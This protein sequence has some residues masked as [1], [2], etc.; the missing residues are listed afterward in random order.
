MPGPSGPRST[1][2]F[3][4]GRERD[5]VSASAAA[6]ELRR[7]GGQPGALHGAGSGQRVSEPPR[8]LKP[9]AEWRS[10]T[11]APTVRVRRVSR[12]AST[13]GGLAATRWRLPLRA[14]HAERDRGRRLRSR[15]G[16]PHRHRPGLGP[17]EPPCDR[18]R[19]RTSRTG[20]TTRAAVTARAVGVS[21]PPVPPTAARRRRTRRSP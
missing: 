13:G 15:R 11:C 3:D 16:P 10:W 14:R 5:R 4:Q 20:L 17:H 19:A 9:G 6:H 21:P 18:D 2:L 1:P 7:C 12:S 8:V